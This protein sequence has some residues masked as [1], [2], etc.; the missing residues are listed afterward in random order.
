MKILAEAAE[1]VHE[2]HTRS[3]CLRDDP[4]WSY[5]FVCDEDGRI[6]ASKLTVEDLGMWLLCAGHDP[7]IIDKGVS[8]HRWKGNSPA[9]GECDDC[10]HRVELSQGLANKCSNP[11]CTAEYDGAG[12]RLA[13]RFLW[14]E[15][16]PV[17]MASI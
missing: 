17:T 5:A 14:P 7:S 4:E 11:N 13:P 3:F 12:Q 1:V 2:S 9:I 8:T 10:G 6:D 15:G 16:E